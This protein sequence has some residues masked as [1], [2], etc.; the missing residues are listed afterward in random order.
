MKNI[1][2]STK[3]FKN[4]C[5]YII[6]ALEPKQQ[7]ALNIFEL[8]AND[9]PDNLMD[10]L[11]RG[12]DNLL[13]LYE[14]LFSNKYKNFRDE[15]AL[16]ADIKNLQEKAMLAKLVVDKIKEM[17]KDDF[18]L[19]RL[20]LFKNRKMPEIAKKLKI[21]KGEAYDRYY[22]LINSIISEVIDLLETKRSETEKFKPY[23]LTNLY[24]RS[25]LDILLAIAKLS[26]KE[27]EDLYAYFENRIENPGL[28]T[29]NI[30]LQCRYSSKIMPK[31][32]EAINFVKTDSSY[33]NRDDIMKMI[34]DA[35]PKQE[36]EVAIDYYENNVTGELTAKII[37][38]IEFIYKII[39]NKYDKLK[40][41]FPYIFEGNKEEIINKIILF[42]E[43][44][45]TFDKWQIDIFNAYFI[46]GLTVL[47]A[48][49][50]FDYSPDVI[51]KI[52]NDIISYINNVMAILLNTDS[53]NYKVE[54]IYK[55]LSNYSSNVILNAILELNSAYRKII[56]EVHGFNLEE[57][58]PV[59]IEKV[60]YTTYVEC[61]LPTLRGILERNTSKDHV[62]GEYFVPNKPSPHMIK[63]ISG[64]KDT[65][66]EN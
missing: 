33:S 30:D 39:V 49:L 54:S 18:K 13:F 15:F 53:A 50:Y 22:I 47:K 59:D 66:E 19:L 38:K 65:K 20:Y 61:I 57:P 21:T 31:L 12:M 26:D 7:L 63:P 17:P 32:T 9:L 27:I 29:L 25:Y 60:P 16:L 62:N 5:K 42:T 48:S 11:L 1:G 4:K 58:N 45:H 10:D 56:F 28:V 43:I 64:K 37:S 23:P 44:I 55:T 41:E 51:E 14:L 40:E 36:K 35:L 46:E 8:S 2:R 3:D 24:S 34:I 6:M 52:L